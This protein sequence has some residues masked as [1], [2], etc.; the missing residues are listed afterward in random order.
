MAKIFL[1]LLSDKPG[2]KRKILRKSQ[3]GRDKK[4]FII[5][6][7]AERLLTEQKAEKVSIKNEE[8]FF[9]TN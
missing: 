8:W 2:N 4:Q 3:I 1:G 7:T 6:T 5:V 9:S